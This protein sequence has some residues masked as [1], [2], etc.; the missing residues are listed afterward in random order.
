MKQHSVNC[1]PAGLYML[2]KIAPELCTKKEVYEFIDSFF[3][4]ESDISEDDK[5]LVRDYMK[6]QFEKFVEE[7]RTTRTGAFP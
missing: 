2:Y 3:S 1:V 6:N 7:G 4:R 5:S